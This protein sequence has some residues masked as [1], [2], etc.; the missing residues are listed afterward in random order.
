MKLV[1]G[2]YL[3]TLRERDELDRLLPD[4]LVEM[5]YV[6]VA[7][8][9]TGNRQFGVDLAA[10]GK[11]P[12]DGKDELLL[13]VIKQGDIG[14]TD[15]DTGVQSV[16]QSIHE[17]FDAYLRG[18]LEPEDQNRRVRIALVT[19]GVLKQTVQPLW[20]G[21]VTEYQVRAKIEFWGM[22][23]LAELVERHLFDEF[24]FRD[25]D[26]KQLRRALALSGDSEYDQ[27]DLHQLFLRTLGLQE[28]GSLQSQPKTEKE[29]L[30]ALRIVNLS[31]HI[32]ASWSATDGDA[33]QGIRAIERAT[34]WSWHRIQLRDESSSSVAIVEAFSSLWIG[35]QATTKRY[36]EKIQ[37][38]CY[39]KDGLY[40]YYSNG[41][42]FSLVAFEQIGI[43]S[44]IGLAQLALTSSEEATVAVHR[45][46]A[47]VLADALANVIE[48]NDICNS[49]CLDRH[50]NEITLA[51]TLLLLSGLVEQAQKWLAMLIRNIDYAYRAKKYVPISNDSLDDLV[52][53][54]GWNGGP[55]VDHLINMSWT[56][57]TLA[58]WCVILG[59][60][61][62]YKIL[63][64]GS[65]EAYP[66]VCM[67]L[68]HP[69]TKIFDHLY[70]KQ[71]QYVSGA[72]EAPIVL[73]SEL[74]DWQAHMLAIVNS[75][76]AK[77]SVTSPA[78]KAGI[79]A[80]DIVACRHFQTPIAP[81]FWYQFA[82]HITNTGD[83][84]S[85]SANIIGSNSEFSN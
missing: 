75:E 80:L 82:T 48:N 22:D 11:H 18:H 70:F 65:K 4:L 37:D 33:R 63:V 71:A 28:D 19:N 50:S 76:Q 69:D 53:G 60:D 44:T 31:A 81:Y 20:N 56:L 40:G 52:E 13:L 46:N 57:P 29:L 12:V 79:L 51:L 73:P 42:E 78:A 3:R 62:H 2:E 15:W 14:R 35:Y 55:A 32:F 34:L 39:A 7:R 16:R 21:L 72:S 41:L 17:I 84:L 61:E 59:L 6:P 9:Q 74:S 26:R 30:K 68:W 85:D 23:K 1:I 43:L 36:F 47:R 10:R 25:E 66:E 49:P 27:R 38:H 58:G 83:N 45:N 54:G 5:G 67:Q 24:V 77:I 8:P 64:R